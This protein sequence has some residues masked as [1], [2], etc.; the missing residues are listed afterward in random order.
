MK[1]LRFWL[2]AWL[3]PEGML[4]DKRPPITHDDSFTAYASG[5]VIYSTSDGTVL[6]YKETT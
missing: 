3:L 6:K 2:A 5:G 4:I 1:R